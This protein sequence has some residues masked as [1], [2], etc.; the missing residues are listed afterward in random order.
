[1]QAALFWIAAFALFSG[2]Y[3][4]LAPAVD[5]RMSSMRAMRSDCRMVRAIDGDTVDLACPGRGTM[6]VR[7]VGYD[8]P[9]LFSPMCEAEHAA[10]LRATQAL[11]NLA[12]QTPV[13]VGFQGHDRYGRW[14]ADMRLGGQRVATAMVKSGNGRR[15]FGSLRGSWC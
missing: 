10:A 13:E 15:Y 7:I 4:L 11:R 6:R 3:A 2:G 5:D 12:R 9:E 1:M 14:L 8:A